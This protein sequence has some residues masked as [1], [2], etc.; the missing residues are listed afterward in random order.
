M[1]GITVRIM[2]ELSKCYCK[3]NLV[4]RALHSK[5]QNY[6]RIV[7]TRPKGRFQ[8]DTTNLPSEMKNTNLQCLLI[9]K[10]HF[11]RFVWAYIVDDKTSLSIS[12]SFKELFKRGYI[13]K[14]MHTDNG[15]EFSGMVT[16]LLLDF[17]IKHVHG[18]PYHPQSQG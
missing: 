10:D 11:S 14:M 6:K 7:S 18:R 17:S 5:L 2:H 1:I 16:E 3:T 9:I 8:A 13:P 12:N 15:S 4:S